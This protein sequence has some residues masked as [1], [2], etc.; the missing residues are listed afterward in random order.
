MQ[1]GG[2]HKDAHCCVAVIL[3]VCRQSRGPSA[4][5]G[6]HNT[7]PAAMQELNNSV[8][9]ST[10]RADIPQKNME[11]GKEKRILASTAL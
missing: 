9:V 11:N 3:K 6:A 8:Y 7:A 2:M 10:S 5:A 4:G 1:S